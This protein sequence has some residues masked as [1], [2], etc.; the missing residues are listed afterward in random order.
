MRLHYGFDKADS[1]CSLLDGGVGEQVCG[2]GALVFIR[3]Y[4]DGEF[5][6]QICPGFNCSFGEAARQSA[7]ALDVG[8]DAVSLPAAEYLI[9][10]AVAVVFE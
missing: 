6:V 9:R 2:Y 7:E 1:L 8:I 10:L 5:G 3:R 4:R